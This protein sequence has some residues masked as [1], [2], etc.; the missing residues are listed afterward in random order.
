MVHI[1]VGIEIIIAKRP[2]VASTL[3]A[4]YNFFEARGS[5]WICLAVSDSMAYDD[6]MEAFSR[7]WLTFAPFSTSTAFEVEHTQAFIYN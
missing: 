5:V 2:L 4:W 7:V 6:F 3:S 1:P